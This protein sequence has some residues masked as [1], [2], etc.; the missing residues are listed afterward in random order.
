MQLIAPVDA[1]KAGAVLVAAGVVL[2]PKL[3]PPDELEGV[4]PKPP[5]ND[6]MIGYKMKTCLALSRLDQM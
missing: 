5:P 2:A 6:A 1:P 4:P 3:N